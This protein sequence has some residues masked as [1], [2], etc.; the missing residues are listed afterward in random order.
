MRAVSVVRIVTKRILCGL[1]ALALTA[2]SA[3]A[4]TFPAKAIRLV[5]PFPPGGPTDVFARQYGNALSK[6]VGQPVVI[7]NKA[8][9]SGAIGALDVMRS[10]ADGYTLIFGTTST[11]A[12]YIFLQRE[13]RFDPAKDFV[14]VAVVGGAPIVFAVHPSMPGTLKEVLDLARAQPGKLQYGSPGT[15]T[16]MHFTT[17]LLKKEAG[18]LD[19]THVPFKGAGP[20]K[21]A[22]L[23][24]Q[25]PILVDTLG[26]SLAEHKAGKLKILAIA[27]PK[28][29]EAAPDIPTVD[30]AIGTRGFAAELWNVVAAPAGTPRPVL[31]TLAAATKKAMTDPQLLQI[32]GQLGIRAEANSDPASAATYVREE[33]ARWRPIVEASGVKLE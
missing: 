15:G 21:Q 28:R 2:S 13:P 29:S 9:A 25:L 8:G 27:M 3:F 26:T 7:D 11:N 19:I 1:A 12:L 16:L 30:E 20:A 31:D 32:L 6:V 33:T 24:A 10:P 17:E 22:V 23:G 4:Q 18:N 14:P 5:V